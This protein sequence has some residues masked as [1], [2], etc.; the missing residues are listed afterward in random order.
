LSL[1]LSFSRKKLHSTYEPLLITKILRNL[2]L[3][4]FDRNENSQ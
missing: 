1:F 3:H 4:Q 2:A